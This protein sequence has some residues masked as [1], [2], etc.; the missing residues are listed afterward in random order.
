MLTLLIMA[1]ILSFSKV[2]IDITVD[3]QMIICAI[4][5]ASDLNILSQILRK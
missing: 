5:I 3:S 4:C 2:P 1:I